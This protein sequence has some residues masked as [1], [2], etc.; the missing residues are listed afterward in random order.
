MMTKDE[1][2]KE[3]ELI[4]ASSIIGDWHWNGEDSV[5][6]EDFDTDTAIKMMLELYDKMQ[7]Q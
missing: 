1:F 7:E 6:E 5:Y 4:L 3:V 2:K